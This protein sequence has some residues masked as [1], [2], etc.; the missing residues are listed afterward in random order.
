MNIYS[1]G[2]II[3]TLIGVGWWLDHNGAQRV[4]AEMKV[5]EANHL[6]EIAKAK[7]E[8]RVHKIKLET[9]HSE[10]SRQIDQARDSLLDACLP[11]W[12][13]KLLPGGNAHIGQCR[14]GPAGA[15]ATERAN[16]PT[17]AETVH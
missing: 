8:I 9:Q 13:L 5:A 17:L 7:A 6:V 4:I 1:I 12:A 11:A 14:T 16:R 3:F 10:I 2:A 15:S